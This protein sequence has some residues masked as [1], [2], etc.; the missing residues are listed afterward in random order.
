MASIQ[1]RV[2]S[3]G[4]ATWRVK[5]RIGGTRDGRWDGETC[6]ELKIARRFNALVEAAGER[7]PEGYPK[8][9]R[10]RRFVANAEPE[11]GPVESSKN[12]EP[13]ASGHASRRTF[14]QVVE[15]YLGQLKR[16]ER[17]QVADYRRRWRQHVES[18]V[19][20]LTDGRRVGPLGALPIEQV[21]G[22]VLQAW[23]TWM[24]RRRWVYGPRDTDPKPYSP[25][26]IANIHG[27]VI[28]PALGFAATKRGYLDANPAAGVELSRPRGRTVTPDCVPA[29][30][31]LEQWITV[32]YSVSVLAGDIVT[33]A[34]GTGLRWG[35]ITALRPCDLDLD[36]GL[37]TVNQVV[38]E[39]ENRRLYIAAYGKSPAALR[40]IRLPE[41]VKGMLRRRIKGLSPRAL[42]FTGARGGILASSGGWHQTHW[43]KVI[44]RAQEAGI[45]TAVTPHKFRHAHAT[46]Q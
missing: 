6:D 8:G 28:C 38:K 30:D 24:E 10:G 25:K 33:L 12:P 1:K 27:G 14:G 34:L 32:G 29:G 13:P 17:R 7:R 45:L 3:D 20:T 5:W 42:I 37:L 15:E 11:S 16:A 21:T 19:V 23:V 41:R 2:G 9:C 22:E 36:A 31:E 4:R 18:A 40:T 46:E 39:D 26:T 35:E 44:K 43:S